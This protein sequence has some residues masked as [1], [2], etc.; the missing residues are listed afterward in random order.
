MLLG[1]EKATRACDMLCMGVG[2]KNVGFGW[3]LVAGGWCR[4][5]A[6]ETRM[7]E[8]VGWTRRRLTRTL[9]SRQLEQP[10][11]GLPQYTMAMAKATE[12]TGHLNS[13]ATGDGATQA[14]PVCRGELRAVHEE[15]GS[16]SRS[17]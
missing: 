9:R 17:R 2:E 14:R 16:R 3:W 6:T 15:E 5:G 4:G 12:I 13:G 8:F 1:G 7:G 11:D 10:L